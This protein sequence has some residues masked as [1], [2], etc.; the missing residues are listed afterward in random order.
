VSNAGRITLRLVQPLVAAI[1]LAAAGTAVTTA[2]AAAV[3]ATATASTIAMVTDLGFP[4]GFTVTTCLAKSKSALKA[5]KYAGITGKTVGAPAIAS[6]ATGKG[7]SLASIFCG[8]GSGGLFVVVSVAS[9]DATFASQHA[10]DLLNAV[11]K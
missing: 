5:A 10:Q 4:T 7:A 11:T 6:I 3:T 2:D 8:Q 9:P 1:A